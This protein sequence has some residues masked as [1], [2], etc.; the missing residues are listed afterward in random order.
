MHE[1]AIT[2]SLLEIALQQAQKHNAHKVTRIN[3][4]IGELSGVEGECV[5]FY[6][7]ILSKDSVAS[8]AA[9]CFQR[10]PLTARCHDCDATFVPGGLDW[11]CPTCGGSRIE[12]VGG[13]EMYVESMELE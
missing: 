10:L 8:G 9:L 4:V 7:D 6:F 1:L 3:L 11:V 2:E 5:K 13:R 12:V